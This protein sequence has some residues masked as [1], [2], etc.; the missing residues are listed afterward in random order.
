MKFIFPLL[1][2]FL[3][4]FPQQSSQPI[5]SN[6][7][8]ENNIVYF[9]KYEDSLVFLQ[10]KLYNEKNDSISA[11]W[12]LKFIQLWEEVLSNQASFSYPFDSLIEIGR[13]YSPDNSFRIIHWNL[14]FENGTHGYYGFIQSYNK[15]NKQFELFKLN[16]FS[17]EIKYPETFIGNHNKWMGMLYYKIIPCNKYYLL[18]GLDLNDKLSRKKIIDVL[19]FKENGDPQFGKSVFKFPKKDPKRLQFEY[20]SDLVMTL[21]YLEEKQLIV[22]DHLAPREKFLEGQFQFY[23]PDFSYDGLQYQK[24]K[25]KYIEDLD[26]KNF[27][28]KKD[29]LWVA[30]KDAVDKKNKKEKPIYKP[31]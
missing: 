9:K 13:L 24:G 19:S 25:W 2:S 17:D 14:E 8:Q 28:N 22:F 26:V 15:K 31:K 23:G 11:K 18:L 1:L 27:K 10:K 21:K 16:D 30:P 5:Y 6:E 29:D 3:S 7:S 12:N 4:V 20:S